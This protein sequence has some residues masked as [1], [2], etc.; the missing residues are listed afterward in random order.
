[1]FAWFSENR[2][3]QADTG[4]IEANGFLFDAV[5]QRYDQ[6]EE[7]WVNAIETV[8]ITD[9]EPGSFEYFRLKITPKEDNVTVGAGLG[10]ISSS[11]AKDLSVLS[12]TAEQP[13]ILSV[14]TATFTVGRNLETTAG[15][16]Y[17]PVYNYFTY[18]L[19]DLQFVR[20]VAAATATKGE[21]EYVCVVNGD[22]LT[23]K[24][25]GENG[26]TLAVVTNIEIN[27]RNKVASLTVIDG[28]NVAYSYTVNADG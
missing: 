11:P 12:A 2:Q 10:S 21:N 24:E 15:T 8:K 25:Q 9:F 6:T 16:T 20:K 3:V 4:A 26:A 7:E 19:D 23:V 14:D 18:A 13:T 5:L 28:A 27:N 17:I 22:T 1:M